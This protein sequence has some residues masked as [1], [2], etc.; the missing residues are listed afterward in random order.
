M[1]GCCDTEGECTG[2]ETI[3][4][5]FDKFGDCIEQ[6]V[7]PQSDAFGDFVAFCCE[8]AGQT[9]M[10]AVLVVD[11]SGNR[12][13]CLVE[14]SVVD[15]SASD[16]IDDTVT[17]SCLDDAGA[18]PAPGAIAAVCEGLVPTMI[19]E[20]VVDNGCGLG[21]I[22]REFSID[23]D[24][25]GTLSP[26]DAFCVQTINI[27]GQAAFDPTTIRWPIHYNLSLIHI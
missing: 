8:D 10:V 15:A 14:V 16:C 22:I 3:C 9:I 18:I 5:A 21:Q 25:D 11:D 17:I 27:T 24:G 1:T 26:G 7:S 13:T 20:T 19:N 4:L 6:G 2:G 23:N 12:N